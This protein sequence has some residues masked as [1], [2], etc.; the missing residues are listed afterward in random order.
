MNLPDLAASLAPLVAFTLLAIGARSYLLRTGV[1]HLS[2]F[3][4]RDLAEP[5]PIGV[6]ED[7]AFAWRWQ[8]A[9]V[10]GPDDI[11]E[12]GEDK[13]PARPHRLDGRVVSGSALR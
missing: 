5:W 3:Y 11:D 9:N 6:Q 8:S 10:E 12:P 1:A 4:R 13:P 7:D 2:L